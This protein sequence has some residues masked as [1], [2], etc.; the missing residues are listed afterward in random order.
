[1][2]MD[3]SVIAKAP[4]FDAGAV[5]RELAECNVPHGESHR[6]PRPEIL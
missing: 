4:Y 6:A 3:R 2:F 1:M 5:A